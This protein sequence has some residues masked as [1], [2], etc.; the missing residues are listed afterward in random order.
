MTD[1]RIQNIYVRDGDTLKDDGLYFDK[2]QA[3]EALP[4]DAVA[5]NPPYSRE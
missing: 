1:I 5:S 2:D 3:Y 4:V